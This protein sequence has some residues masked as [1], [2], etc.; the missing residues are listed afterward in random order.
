MKI[1]PY[2]VLTLLILGSLLYSC[3]ENARPSDFEIT[4][5]AKKDAVKNGE[6][7]KLS[8]KAKKQTTV[9][10]VTYRLEGTKLGTT[11]SLTNYAITPT[12]KTLGYKT[13]KATVHTSQGPLEITKRIAILNTKA[14]KVYGYEIVNKY[15]H[16]TDAYTQGLEFVGDELYESTGQ[17]GKSKLRKVNY[18]TG[19]VE[20]EIALDNAYF[21]EGMTL[22]NDKIYQL[23]W[24]E[25]TGFIYDRETF[26][27]TG[28]F[29][30]NKSREGWGLC[31]DGN[32]FYKSDGTSKIWTLD[33]KTLQEQS[34]IEPTD[35]T[36]VKSK[37][38][39]L[40][41]IN[42]KIYANT[43]GIASI[44]I[45]NPTTGAMEGV[46]DLRSIVKEVQSGL[47]KRNHVLNGIAYK[48][49]EDRLFVTGKLWNTLFE[50][51]I[52]EK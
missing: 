42:G 10:S 48:T 43:Y 30:Y 12:V 15:T 33:S 4:T 36:G 52:V 13:L 41:F 44:A 46:V 51:K 39:E 14:P 6:Q 1:S 11:N 7:I 20:N 17:Y 22:L 49:N 40:E 25:N 35:H 21:A 9:D 18:K 19:E 31:N 23:T 2:K 45:I 50:I 37:F 8:L 3:E 28:T 47:D 38:N 26:K 16:Q 32:V 27:K 5:N 24:K 29:T 34:Y